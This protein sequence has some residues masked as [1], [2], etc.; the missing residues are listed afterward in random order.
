MFTGDL[1]MP[2]QIQAITYERAFT[3]RHNALIDA[4]DAMR[5][6]RNLLLNNNVARALRVAEDVVGERS[7]AENAD[8][9]SLD[10][11]ESVEDMQTELLEAVQLPAPAAP[12]APFSGRC[13]RLDDA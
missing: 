6:V 13:F 2:Q 4:H 11:D 3:M 10:D 9:E 1:Q 7:D 8:E 12:Q 5:G